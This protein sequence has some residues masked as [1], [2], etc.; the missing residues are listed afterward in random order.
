MAVVTVSFNSLHAVR[1]AWDADGRHYVV[2]GSRDLYRSDNGGSSYSLV[3]TFPD[4]PG[5]IYGLFVDSQ[6]RVWVSTSWEASGIDGR[7]YRSTDYGATFTQIT[8]YEAGYNSGNIAWW[9]MVEDTNGDLYVGQY[10]LTKGGPN[11]IQK[12]NIWKSTNGGTSW[13]NIADASWS[14]TYHIHGL[15]IDTSTGWLYATTGD[16]DGTDGIWRS[17][18]KDGTDWVRKTSSTNLQFIPV[19]FKDGYV[20]SADDSKLGQV[21]RFQDDGTSTG[22]TPAVVLNTQAGH[23]NY[24]LGKDN[25]GRLWTC[26]ANTSDVGTVGVAGGVWVSN[27]GVT[28]LKLII[29]PN[30]A[31]GDWYNS[32]DIPASKWTMNTGT[33]QFGPEDKAM[34]P[35]LNYNSII[36]EIA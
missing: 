4:N 5:R 14:A 20:Y 15:G 28:W 6:R 27:D 32:S 24:Y 16:V 13:T 31:Y 30:M 33:Q 34:F 12:C 23:N 18:L 26:F 2:S 36:I 7:S 8:S 35:W 9:P 1:N 19:V 3:Y 17:K 11:T 25:S 22:I 10:N 29:A 21:F